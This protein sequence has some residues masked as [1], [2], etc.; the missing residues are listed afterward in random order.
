MTLAASQ[1][2]P[3]AVPVCVQEC[4]A[5]AVDCGDGSCCAG[6]QSCASDGGC[7]DSGVQG[8]LDINTV[9]GIAQFTTSDMWPSVTSPSAN[10][11]FTPYT[12]S[13]RAAAPSM[14]AAVGGPAAG[15]IAFAAALM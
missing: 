9:A 11:T 7:I 2:K 15:T 4:A 10:P 8:K 1:Q 12:I 14:G 6:G 13:L 5:D 3:M